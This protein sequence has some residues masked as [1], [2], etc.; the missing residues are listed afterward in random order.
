M[1]K[2]RTTSLHNPSV[3][4]KIHRGMEMA[5]RKS[6]TWGVKGQAYILNRRG[7]LFMRI[8]HDRG[9]PGAFRFWYQSR[10]DVTDLVLAQLRACARMPDLNL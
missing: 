7:R 8:D 1:N 9:Q 6:R 3:L 2:F 5:V 4:C 10:D